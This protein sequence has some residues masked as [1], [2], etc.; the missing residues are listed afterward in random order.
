GYLYAQVSHETKTIKKKTIV[1]YTIKRGPAWKFGD[2]TF[3]SAPFLTDSIAQ[4]RKNF[5]VLHKG[6]K[7]DATMLKVERDRIDNDMKNNGFFF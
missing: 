1:T 3:P 2:I 7:F 5:S 6:D 4:Q